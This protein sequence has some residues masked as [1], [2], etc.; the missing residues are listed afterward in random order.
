MIGKKIRNS[1]VVLLLFVDLG[2]AQTLGRFSRAGDMTTPRS[3][4]TATLLPTGQVLIAGG[5]HA[6]RIGAP[7]PRLDS[8]ELYDPDTDTFAAT[9][10]MT[11]AR[12]MHAATQLPDGRV[13]IA[14]GY[15]HNNV[16]ASAEI[17]DPSTGTFNP[18]GGMITARAGHS[19]ILL[20]NGTVLIVGGYGLPGYPN[21]AAAE[22]YDPATGKF[23]ATGSYAGSGGCDFCPPAMLLPDG[24]V[25]FAGQYPA[26]LF[27]PVTNTFSTTGKMNLDHSEAVVLPN[28]MVLFAGG[29]VVGRTATAELYDPGN[30]AFIFTG[31]MSAPRVWHTLTLLP[32]GMALAAGGETELCVNNFCGFAGSTPSTELYDPSAGRFVSAGNMNAR[33]GGHTATVLND[34]RILLAGGDEYGGIGLFFGT[35]SSAEL[36]T[37][38]VLVPAPVLFAVSENNQG[39]IFHADTH[40]A[41]SHS[42]PAIAG[43]IL[44]IYLTGLADESVIPPQVSIGGRMAEVLFFGKFPGVPEL[45]QVNVRMP[46][47]VAAGPAIPVR[48]AYIGQISNEVTIAVQ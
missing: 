34:G 20:R 37:P 17:Y 29:A 43:E 25:L 48:M 2:I 15:G 46:G 42:H 31:N 41:A 6:T 13:L 30:G 16:L 21:V 9:G 4:H 40:Q 27:D 3:G 28:G 23:S 12:F 26:Q 7:E 1:F 35:V 22:V 32:N 14:G 44:E 36:F 38:S 45:N 11:A 19:A 5:K 33:R 24:K 47:G 18:T 8:A 39:A 10:S